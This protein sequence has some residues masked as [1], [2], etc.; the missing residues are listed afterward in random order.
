MNPAG[1]SIGRAY[2]TPGDHVPCVICKRD[3]EKIGYIALRTWLGQDGVSSW[4]YYL[5]R[6]FLGLWYGKEAAR[7]A[8]TILK[9]VDP[10]MPIKLSTE[11]D[12]I[13]AQRLYT[14]IG[15]VKSEEMD[16]DDLVF[17]L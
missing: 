13:K 16:G 10:Q 11:A 4:S 1:F 8:V 12:N 2:L 7:L 3:G 5:D 17:V 14:S 6:R 9:A 15:F